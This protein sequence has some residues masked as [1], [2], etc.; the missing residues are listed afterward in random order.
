M[1]TM[2]T[3]SIAEDGLKKKNSIHL[4]SEG[5]VVKKMDSSLEK[6]VFV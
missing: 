4:K 5:E 1:S 2:R 6:P 3:H